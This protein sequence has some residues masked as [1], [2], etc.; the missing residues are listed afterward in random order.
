MVGT[1][2]HALILCATALL[3]VSGCERDRGPTPGEVCDWLDTCFGPQ[4]PGCEMSLIPS[5]EQASEAGCFAEFTAQFDC[6]LE[7]GCNVD[8]SECAEEALDFGDCI[9][10][11]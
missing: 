8:S 2:S 11:Q 3:L 9:G 4:P 6:L 1:S 5:F 7:Q 10:V